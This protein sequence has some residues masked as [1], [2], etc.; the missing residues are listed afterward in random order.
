M[1][2]LFSRSTPHGLILLTL[3]GHPT[4]SAHQLKPWKCLNI[5]GFKGSGAILAEMDLLS[6]QARTPANHHASSILSA[7]R[8]WSRFLGKAYSPPP[9]TRSTMGASRGSIRTDPAGRTVPEF[10]SVVLLL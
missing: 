4:I 2:V 1:Y 3:S 8:L 10:S 6:L 9:P 7:C 5:E